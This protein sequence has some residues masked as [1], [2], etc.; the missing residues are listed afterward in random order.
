MENQT[1]EET[2]EF[3]CCARG[4]HLT[5]NQWKDI[6]IGES[7]TVCHQ[8]TINVIGNVIICA[9]DKL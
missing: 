8:E 2:F 9:S 4:Y 3:D 7:L 1:T 5:E 6:A